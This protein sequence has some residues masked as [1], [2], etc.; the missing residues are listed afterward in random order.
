MW[1]DFFPNAQIYGADIAPECIFE[2]ER[3]KTYFCDERKKEDI[4]QLIEQTGT[5]IDLVIDDG[6]HRMREQEF[7]CKT[8]MPLLKEDVIYIIEDA[9]HPERLVESLSEYLCFIPMLP[10]KK[11]KS[12]DRLVIVRRK[13]VPAN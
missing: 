1:R 6:V 8:L 12:G 13:Y 10:P 5:D 2:E 3:I 7:L 4:L 11:M 9:S